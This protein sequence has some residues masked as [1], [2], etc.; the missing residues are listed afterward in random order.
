MLYAYKKFK[1]ILSS[2]TLLN[3]IAAYK[4]DY[5]HHYIKGSYKST[6]KIGRC[7]SIE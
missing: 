4:T 1:F 7:Q 5:Y 6:T 3:N 2:K